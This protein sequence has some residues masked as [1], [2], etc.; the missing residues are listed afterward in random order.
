MYF[1][2]CARSLAGNSLNCSMISVALMPTKY[3]VLAD[4]ASG[5]AQAPS[6][7]AYL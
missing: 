6:G 5:A 7:A 1:V 3:R 2:T 4:E